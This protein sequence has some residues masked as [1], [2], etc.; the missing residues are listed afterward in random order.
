MKAMSR[1]SCAW[2]AL[3][4]VC[5]LG[6]DII[7]DDCD[8]R[9]FLPQLKR[10]MYWGYVSAD[11]WEANQGVEIGNV[12]HPVWHAEDRIFV[13]TARVVH[14][15]GAVG[16]F[17]VMIDPATWAFRGIRTLAS[18]HVSRDYDYEPSTGDF[19]LTFSFTPVDIQ[20]IWARA[21]G[22]SLEAGATIRDAS[23]YPLCAR[24]VDADA[25]VLYAH[26]PATSINGFY[27]VS[28]EESD[29][30]SLLYSVDL[31]EADAR[32]FDVTA[33]TL[34][35]GETDLSG[36]PKAVIRVIDIT[37][38]P[39]PRYVTTLDAVFVSACVHPNGTCAIIS[40]YDPRRPGNVV[41]L[42][43]LESGA[44]T[45]I[46]IHTRPC[47]F[48]IADY[49]SWNPDGDAFA[50]SASAFNGEGALYPRQLWVRHSVACP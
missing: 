14:G 46:N 32:G 37:S 9:P 24:F 43:D 23:W 6:C 33:G 47:A 36:R 39:N 42:V 40:V 31:S 49:A 45:E 48:P 1:G 13:H 25:M 22:D 50:F 11:H 27:F 30:D 5:F 19:A 26:N 18:P 21:A 35:F 7:S 44:F 8:D 38:D 16:I 10:V 2:A 15:E 34:C 17:N 41:G 20:T 29:L 28:R 3:A 12:Y 4:I